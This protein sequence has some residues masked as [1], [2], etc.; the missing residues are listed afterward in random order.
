MGL[1]MEE[2]GQLWGKPGKQPPE[3]P[4]PIFFFINNAKELPIEKTM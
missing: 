1:G 3:L 2:E 4:N